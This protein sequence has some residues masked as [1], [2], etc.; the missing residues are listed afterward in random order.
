MPQPPSRSDLAQQFT[1]PDLEYGLYPCWWWEGA[2]ICKEKLTWQL[3]EMKRVGS[4]GTFFYLRYTGDDRY[5]VVPKYG[6]DEFFEMFKFSLEEHRRLG[7]K[8]YFSE[9][10]G[11]NAIENELADDPAERAT[12]TGRRLVLHES[13]SEAPGPLRLDIPPADEI[14]CAAAYRITQ[15]GLDADSRVELLDAVAGNTLTWIAPD[16][17]WSLTA[18]A[19]QASGLD[20][21]NTG[22]A[23]RWVANLYKPFIKHL[24]E[25]FGNSFKGYIQDELDVLSGDIIYSPLL[26]EAFTADNGYDPRPE[27]VALF[28]DVGQRTDKIRCQYYGTMSGLLEKNVYAHLSKW[29]EARNLEYGTI[30]VRG[31]QD[32]L[33]ETGHFG[34]LFALMRWYHFPGNEDPHITPDTPRRR[35]FID[36]KISSSAAHIFERKR[37]ALCAYWG[38]GWGLTFEQRMAWTNE[39]Y[40]YGMNLY[41]PH[42]AG[43]SLGGGWYEWVPPAHYFYQPH[44]AHYGTF[45]TYVRR[46][47]Y[48][49]SQ[50]VH[51][52]DVALLFPTTA[53]HANWLCGNR[54]T[55][56]ADDAACS[57]YEMAASIY[58]GGID[59]D[60]MDERT[61]CD[62]EIRDGK[63]CVA[64]M[65]FGAVALPPM[66]TIR[67]AS[68]R[69][70][71]ALFDAG[72]VVVAYRGVPG[73]SA[74]VG[75]DD[76]EVREIVTAMF[77]AA[78]SRE[79]THPTFQPPDTR[80]DHFLNGIHVAQNEHGG[81]ALFMPGEQNKGMNASSVDLPSVLRCVMACDVT[82]DHDVYHTH[83]KI[84]DVDVYFLYNA[85]DEVDKL[86]V[87]FRMTGQPEIWD[88]FTGT[89]QRC[90]RFE[91]SAEST[92]IRLSMAKHQA[93]IVS[94]ASGSA[95]PTV[96]ADNLSEITSIVS[97][98]DGVEVYGTCSE[99]GKKS[100]RLLHDSDTYVGETRV[101]LPPDPLALGGEWGV[102]LKPT[103]DNRWGDYRYPASEAFIGAEAR[104]F[105]YMEEDGRPG[106]ELGWQ[107]P[108]LDDAA[109]PY[110]TFSW[111]PY[112]Y[113]AGPFSQDEL[114]GLPDK[115]LADDSAT[116]DQWERYTFSQDY[117]HDSLKMTQSFGGLEGVPD[118]FIFFDDVPG[119]NDATR[120]ML[121]TI[122][123]PQA[124]DWDLVV[125]GPTDFPRRAW[126][127]GREV[128]SAGVLP[129]VEA[130]A[131]GLELPSFQQAP[132]MKQPP[133]MREP[134][135]RTTVALDAGPN[136]VLLELVQP[137]GESLRAYAAFVQP[138]A[139]PSAGL[140]PVPRV[141]WFMDPSGL[142]Y[143]ILPD[144]E[145]RVGWYRFEAPAGVQRIMV[146]LDAIGMEAWID[147][148][149]VDVEDGRIEIASPSTQ[150]SQV[151][152]RITQKPGRYGGAAIET[153]ITFSCTPARMPLG[154]WCSYALESYSGG[155]VYSRA[156]RL[157]DQQIAGNVILDLGQVA[158][159]AEVVV[160]GH[161]V[162][163]GLARP[164]RFDITEQIREGDNTLDVTVYNTLANHY[165]IG[166]PS[167]FVYDGQTVSGLLGPVTLAFERV[168]TVKCSRQR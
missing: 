111:G 162:G 2:P 150:I 6:S 135:T 87:T 141:K 7:M 66:S 144:A 35:R 131:G 140:P 128:M 137:H 10:T 158:V 9:W 117:G 20:W 164:F 98:R 25:F 17:G 34:D 83:Q 12:L 136:R 71:K 22:V 38:T 26:L 13:Q 119:S 19:S 78:S 112:W 80:E 147:G 49:M 29:H 163:I 107:S 93:V 124:G 90:Y 73:A 11:E 104:R 74:E 134:E 24:S 154:D 60:F 127:N 122:D 56:A 102:C 4:A 51:A 36:A 161:A 109:W 65:A 16:A 84:G 157:D 145:Q 1:D 123:A 43:Y 53:I 155:V 77:G 168:I 82:T 99:G 105:R 126:I 113:A 139:E 50:G 100:V 45:S 81:T 33:A 40:A 153:P 121:T 63:L 95:R 79:Y 143:D 37:A 67:I 94:F 125:G 69:K 52:A 8:A 44:W 116:D 39:N 88:A 46:L 61:L 110:S 58:Q 138:G 75:R 159:S 166:I 114:P 41:D 54:F 55:L 21:L 96:V 151:A 31:R 130:T 165:S 118:Y 57:V 132:P 129:A 32:A 27:L 15:D 115:F 108:E 72:G 106:T 30:A 3:E 92:T 152:L 18:V 91:H 62:A 148:E 28:H 70:I 149:A 146:P 133:E 64:G 47:S 76:P 59:F 160:N 42:C 23:D 14:L 48:M 5:A 120:Y 103:M 89:V 68:L 85:G 101:A 97:Y 142:T 86:P 156:F 167:R